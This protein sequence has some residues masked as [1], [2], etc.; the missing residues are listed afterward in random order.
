MNLNRLFFYLIKVFIVLQEWWRNETLEIRLILIIIIIITVLF[1][2]NLPHTKFN[3]AYFKDFSAT[4]LKLVVSG[5]HVV[6][7]DDP[8][9]LI[10]ILF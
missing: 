6:P 4:D 3:S 5:R 9:L 7:N 1:Y 2:Y 8:Q 10:I